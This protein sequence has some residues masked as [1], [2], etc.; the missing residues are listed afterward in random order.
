MDLTRRKLLTGALAGGAVVGAASLTACSSGGDS[1]SASGSP[2]AASGLST[3]QTTP[4]F[5]FSS[6]TFNDE[7]LF[8][9]GGASSLVSEPGEIL[10][11]AQ[12]INAKSGNPANPTTAAFDD[13][14]DG[15][16]S[17]GD[18]L[19][20]SAN[21]AGSAHPVTM[22]NRLMRAATCST[23][24]LFFVLG[25]SDGQREES[26]Y[27]VTQR[28]WLV[29]MKVLYPKMVQASVKS[30]FGPLPVYFIPAP[31]GGK[32]PTLIISSGIDGQNVESMQFGVTAGLQRRY[33]IVLF[34]GPGQMSLLFKR[35]IPFTAKWNKVVAPVL[36]WT[37]AR[38]DVGK[39]GLVGV[40]FGGMLCSSAAAKVNGFDAAVLQPAA[41]NWPALW[42]DQATMKIVQET[43]SAP[44]A[45]KAEATTKV[46]EGFLKAWPGLSR[47]SQFNTYKRGEVFTASA[48]ADARAGKPISNYYQMLE[49]ML[50]F[51]FEADFRAITIPTMITMNEG[52]EFDKDQPLEAFAML[53]KVPPSRKVLV[54]LTGAQ[55][56]ALHD[57]PTGP[58]VAQEYIFD[59]LDDQIG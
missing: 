46:N 4:L 52:D 12:N 6:Q 22:A 27:E 2:T 19:E 54:K 18:N 57:Q 1:A 37:R 5:L 42:G 8:A 41:W 25:T 24:Q 23:Q 14:Y 45:Q 33:N 11:I 49:A 32:R 50:P 53:D 59:W 43:A 21:K 51:N 30:E 13:L 29:A 39:V 36:A 48:Q 16:G 47:T 9:L 26:I 35:N 28:R 7:V 15:F 10:R 56:A 20:Q 38:S 44:P 3:S 34:E 31:G 40:S 58:Q 55:G 17:F